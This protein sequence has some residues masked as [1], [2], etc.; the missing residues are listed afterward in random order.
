MEFSRAMRK[1]SGKLSRREQ[2]Y[3]LAAHTTKPN[4]KSYRRSVRHLANLKADSEQLQGEIREYRENKLF[5]IAEAWRVHRH[6][7]NSR[8]PD[9]LIIDLETSWGTPPGQTYRK[10]FQVCIRDA[11][12][13]EIIYSKI[14][15]GMTVRALYNLRDGDPWRTQVVKWYGPPSDELTEGISMHQF[16]QILEQKAVNES[17]YMI[18]QSSNFCDHDNLYYNLQEIDKQHLIP[19]RQHVF[20]LLRG[21]QM[22]FWN[23]KMSFK[24][25]HMHR[26]L[27]PEDR[28]LID[29]AHDA[30]ADE[31]MTYKQAG[32]FFRGTENRLKPAGIQVY[33]KR[34]QDLSWQDF[35]LTKDSNGDLLLPPE[36][37]TIKNIDDDSREDFDDLPFE[38][39]PDEFDDSP[40]DEDFEEWEDLADCD[41]DDADNYESDADSSAFEGSSTGKALAEP[42]PTERPMNIVVTKPH[43]K[44]SSATGQAA[45]VRAIKRPMPREEQKLSPKLKSSRRVANMGTQSK[46]A[47]RNPAKKPSDKVIDS[48]R[49]KNFQSVSSL[50][51]R[52]D[53]TK[54]KPEN[55]PMVDADEDRFADG[56]KSGTTSQS[57]RL[58]SSSS[59]LTLKTTVGTKPESVGFYQW[60]G[61]ISHWLKEIL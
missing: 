1:A 27:F 48:D 4:T 22:A 51:I 56:S 52:K 3:G 44:R 11:A 19:K 43:S 50:P 46:S 42:P 26:L 40:W 32:A 15:Q 10:I 30:G 39:Y 31:I 33:F 55:E 24:L 23:F 20:R 28:A 16:A 18:E 8:S 57:A 7:Y 35:D 38:H 60:L 34:K 49:I 25:S 21:F 6:L 54:K 61:G 9:L 58:D 12:R 41:L 5:P 29:K 13:N 17:K 36:F 53:R 37:E 2:R 14:S 45:K 47:L 59:P